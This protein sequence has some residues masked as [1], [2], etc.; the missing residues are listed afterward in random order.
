MITDVINYNMRCIETVN[1]CIV[2]VMNKKINYNMRC[3]ETVDNNSGGM[4][5]LDKLQHE[6]Y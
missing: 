2:K 6:M 3:I 1:V 4:L 5:E